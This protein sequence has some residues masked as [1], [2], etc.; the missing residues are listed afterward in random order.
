MPSSYWD[1]ADRA[2]FQEYYPQS[3]H[4]GGGNLEMREVADLMNQEAHVRALPLRRFT[5]ASLV[6]AAPRQWGIGLGPHQLEPDPFRHG[7]QYRSY[8]WG[9]R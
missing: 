1:D 4:S 9:P 3:R 5:S 8:G 2:L 6:S 7:N